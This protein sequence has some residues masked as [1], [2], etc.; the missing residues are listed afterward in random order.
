MINSNLRLSSIDSPLSEPNTVI[1]SFEMKYDNYEIVCSKNNELLMIGYSKLEDILKPPYI[2]EFKYFKKENYL[3]KLIQLA[4]DLSCILEKP[5]VRNYSEFFGLITEQD[6]KILIN[7]CKKNGLPLYGNSIDLSNINKI[8]HDKED[9]TNSINKVIKVKHHFSYGYFNIQIFLYLLQRV[10]M[11]F[12]RF[13]TLFDPVM[14][15]QLADF[16]KIHFNAISDITSPISPTF[17]IFET[18]LMQNK[19]N[20]FVFEILTFNKLSM[21]IYQLSLLYTTSNYGISISQKTYTQKCKLCGIIFITD[22]RRRKYCKKC[23][24]QKAWNKKNR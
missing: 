17:C 4:I 6:K 12:L 8:V 5:T 14:K 23:S 16:F 24:P 15:A 19:K 18:L 3:I 9:I 22:Q 13:C 1:K 10:Y 11:D 2:G 20:E 21:A 7:F